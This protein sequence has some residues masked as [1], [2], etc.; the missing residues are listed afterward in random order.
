MIFIVSLKFKVGLQFS[1][2]FALLL[3]I[4]SSFASLNFLLLIT[5]IFFSSPQQVIISFTTCNTGLQ[6]IGFGPKFQLGF[7]E[8]ES[9]LLINNS[10][11][12]KYP[13]IG[14]KTCCQ[15][16]VAS[17]LRIINVFYFLVIL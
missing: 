2:F 15:G 3:L 11:S 4:I 16:L 6:F 8:V 7:R 9:F 10:P 13:D 12:L 5:F 17:G 1:S 14:S